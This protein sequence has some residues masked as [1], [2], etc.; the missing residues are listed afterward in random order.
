M[1]RSAEVV[2]QKPCIFYLMYLPLEIVCLIMKPLDRMVCF[3]WLF[4]LLCINK[5]SYTRFPAYLPSLCTYNQHLR[6]NL[7]YNSRHNDVPFTAIRRQLREYVTTLSMRYLPPIDLTGFSRLSHIS[8]TRDG[9]DIKMMRQLPSLTSL[10]ISGLA[11]TH[12]G[13]K[14]HNQLHTLT[15]LKCLQM[16]C[17]FAAI[18]DECLCR[19]TGLTSLDISCIRY[20]VHQRSVHRDHTKRN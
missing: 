15:N 14:E 12:N 3:H 10:D 13:T 16:S 6:I 5:E 9:I 11:H 7:D 2:S 4:G 17:N 20:I 1:K 18:D 19:M 8:L